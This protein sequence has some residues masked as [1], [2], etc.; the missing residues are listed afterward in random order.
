MNEQNAL[1]SKKIVREYTDFLKRTSNL[2]DDV[3][4]ATVLSLKKVLKLEDGD[5]ILIKEDGSLE[6]EAKENNMPE[7]KNDESK[8]VTL[9]GREVTEAELQRQ[10]EAIQNQKG[11]RLEEESKGKFR[12][13]LND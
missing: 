7:Q 6:I 13:H 3:K 9:N 1:V 12:L 5:S 10:R 11:A 2:I 4:R 8:K